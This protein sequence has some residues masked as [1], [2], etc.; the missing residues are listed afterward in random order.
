MS[1]DGVVCCLGCLSFLPGVK[2]KLVNQ[3]AFFP[4]KPSGYYI[5][6]QKQVYLLTDLSETANLEALPD[7]ST[8]GI[9]VDTV[10]LRTERGDHIFGFHFRRAD[11][12]KTIIFSHGNST[13]IGIMFHHLREISAKLKVDVFAYEYTGYGQSSGVPSE[14][15]LYADI[16]GAYRYLTQECGLGP[17]EIVLYGQSVGSAPT[18]DLAARQP[19]AGVILHSA[20]KSGLAVIRDVKTTHWF[21][22]FQNLAKIQ[23][24]NCPV[25]IIHGT[26]DQEVPFDH[27]VSLYDACPMP[28][29]PWW[30]PEGGHNDI[31]LVWRSTFFIRVQVFLMALEQNTS[32]QHVRKEAGGSDHAPLLN[33]YQQLTFP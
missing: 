25:F 24:V 17:E 4:P 20:L 6:E 33:N 7:L 16:D 10:R 30:V 5:S 28:F 22:V 32:W 19:V 12:R 2:K 31:E 8:E 21:D 18:I 27:G 13:D 26:K 29:E 14:K 23:N 11:S 1:C 3:V 9:Q 15:A